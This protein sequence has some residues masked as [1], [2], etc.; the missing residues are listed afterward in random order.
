MD[1]RADGTGNIDAL[2][3]PGA[4]IE[5]IRPD[6]EIGGQRQFFDRAA[7]RDIGSGLG[8]AIE[9][10]K[11][12]EEV[13]ETDILR[14]KGA[15]VDFRRIAIGIVGFRRIGRCSGAECA[16][17]T[18]SC[19]NLCRLYGRLEQTRTTSIDHMTFK[20]ADP[21]Y[22]TGGLCPSALPVL[23]LAT[24]IAPAVRQTANRRSC[25]KRGVEF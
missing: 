2:V 15:G 23:L 21:D 16:R 13:R 10:L 7:R 4:A 1:R 19:E 22:V 6:A 17:D 24:W 25:C 18:E 9:A 8:I 11:A 3:H 12:G 5:R 14:P 20:H